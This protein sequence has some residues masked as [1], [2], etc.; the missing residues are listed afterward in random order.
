MKPSVSLRNNKEI[1]LPSCIC[2]KKLLLVE[3]VSLYKY[4]KNFLKV[5]ILVVP[6]KCC[7]CFTNCFC[8]TIHC[9]AALVIISLHFL[10]SIVNTISDDYLV[11][12][13]FEVDASLTDYKLEGHKLSNHLYNKLKSIEKSYAQN[14]I[15]PSPAGSISSPVP[16]FKPLGKSALKD[17]EIPT[18]TISIESL[19][20]M[21]KE[22]LSITN[23]KI[24]CTLRKDNKNWILVL[25]YNNIVEIKYVRP[26]EKQLPVNDF[27]D[28]LLSEVAQDIYLA[29][30]PYRLTLYFC[31]NN[32]FD[33]ALDSVNRCYKNMKESDL[34]MISYYNL[35]GFIL[36][37]NGYFDE[38]YQCFEN[39]KKIAK[40]IDSDDGF[41]DNNWGH[42]LI[43]HK[44]FDQ[45]IDKYKSANKIFY[46]DKENNCN[47]ISR[48]YNNIGVAYFKQ[49]D[50]Q[51]ALTYF[52]KALSKEYNPENALAYKNLGNL[53]YE[54]RNY[55]KALMYYLNALEID[56]GYTDVINNI[57]LMYL[58]QK[59]YQYAI[60]Q[61]KNLIKMNPD[62]IYAYI[63]WAAVLIYVNKQ[64]EAKEKLKKALEIDPYNVEA[65]ANTAHIFSTEEEYKKAIKKLQEVSIIKPKNYYAYFEWAYI[66]HV[67]Q[68][69]L[70]EA[71][72]I[73]K[74]AMENAGT[75]KEFA[76]VYNNM[77]DI[78]LKLTEHNNALK[79]TEKAIKKDPE[80]TVPYQTM[81]EVY[82][83]K[84]EYDKA[85]EYYNKYLLMIS[86]EK[87]LE[88][89]VEGTTKKISEVYYAK[90][91]YDKALKYYEKYLLMIS[92]EKEVEDITKKIKKIKDKIKK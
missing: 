59:K 58:F 68:I 1:T 12:E 41:I 37:K 28:K 16:N 62:Y 30:D 7:Y 63:N 84:K 50:L 31:S 87:G 89:E 67:Y 45:A 69:K 3:T 54:Q 72:K 2:L 64:E 78:Y 35:K 13:P 8:N 22:F 49:N 15:Y 42:A 43:E 18:T 80:A 55:Q 56:P 85:L 57:G 92:D 5:N 21:I 34:T 79:Y 46:Q 47:H 32:L 52:N 81:G 86:N 82:D 53:Y 91:E 39:A 19:L 71:L 76:L 38:A 77:A 29:K 25:S 24:Q 36:A 70:E 17:I 14:Q 40:K 4:N 51:K 27:I 65:I 88:K 61:F 66:L 9:S 44:R 60:T 75:N 26:K 10:Y 74:K 11:I 6:Q 83:A 90:K 73:Y 23:T 48:T 33:K 20:N